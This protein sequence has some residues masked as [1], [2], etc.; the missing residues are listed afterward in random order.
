M[1]RLPPPILTSAPGQVHASSVHLKRVLKR[2]YVGSVACLALACGGG[3]TTL[4]VDEESAADIGGTPL[5]GVTNGAASGGYG[6]GGRP[7]PNG[8]SS[9][10]GRHT[11]KTLISGGHHSGGSSSTGGRGSGG[12]A[13]GG[14][15]VTGGRAPTG[16]LASTGGRAPTGGA[17]GNGGIVTGGAATGWLPTG[18]MPAIGGAALTGGRSS[19]GG[20]GNTGNF[21]T[22]GIGSGGWQTGGSV[23]SG[24]R[25]GSGGI[26][27]GGTSS[28]DPF[29]GGMPSM[30][31]TW[32]TGG[33]PGN[34]GMPTGGTATGG[35]STG[36]A[37]GNG[38]HPA[39]GGAT[40]GA[41][42][43]GGVASGGVASGGTATGGVASGGTLAT[44]GSPCA[45][46]PAIPG[47]SVVIDWSSARAATAE[48][49][50]FFDAPWPE[51]SRSVAE[52][53]RLPNPSSARG[54]QYS[55]ADPVTRLI[56]GGI[57]PLEYRAY[58]NQLASN[59]LT[60]G[61]NSAAI[62]FRFDGALNPLAFPSAI[63]TMD[64][65]RSPILLFRVESTGARRSRL[66]PVTS[67]VF[68]KSRY[69]KPHTLSLLPHPGFPLEP[70]ALYAAVILRSLGDRGGRPLGSP[71]AM[72]RAKHSASCLGDPTYETAFAAL[73]ADFSIDRSAVAAMTVFRTGNPAAPLTRLVPAI[74]RIAGAAL[75]NPAVETSSVDEAS[76]Y[77]LVDGSFQ[78]PI[79][80]YADP[81]YLPGIGVAWSGT[82]PV[83]KVAFDPTSNAGRF[84]VEPPPTS[85]T[86]P[87]LAHPRLERIKFRMTLPLGQWSKAGFER[88]PLA[89]VGPG[90][91][92]D[93]TE[94]TSSG[95]AS[96]LARLGIATFCA[97][98][99][100]H[101]ERAHAENVDPNLTQALALYDLFTGQD[102]SSQFSA[103]IANG[104]LFFNP[105]NLQAAKGNSLQAALDYAWQAHF[106]STSTL[107]VLVE[108]TSIPVTFD[109]DKVFFFGHSQGGATGPLLSESGRIGSMVLSAP[110]GH[111]VSNLLG[112][113]KPAQPFE[114]SSAVSSVI[115]DDPSEPL[116]AHHP[117][118]NVL[119]HWFEQA[120]AANYAPRLIAESPNHPKHV[121]VLTGTDDHYVSPA[122]HDAITTAARLHELAPQLRAVPGQQLLSVI[123]PTAGYALSYPSLSGNLEVDG[124]LVTGAFAQYHVAT[125]SDDH[126]VYLCSAD[127]ITDWE[128][129]FASAA[130]G[131][132]PRVNH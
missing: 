48:S 111:L 113:T 94:A 71:A 78:T 95:I 46:F 104:N 82:T 89:I 17:L 55:V 14:L 58:V 67:R 44:G 112:K 68:E 90:T 52:L 87:D 26:A 13:I 98:P 70:D 62:F 128:T 54:C 12:K 24:G 49:L 65:T 63:E 120:D 107:S 96:R 36:G 25:V 43:G 51:I 73:E 93:R 106:L 23:A 132:T 29:T 50:D 118:L 119:L 3:R 122:S 11:G 123:A 38:G 39:G 37:P 131:S 124:R 126:F 47:T 117:Q 85:A 60:E 64:A 80:Q 19:S 116:D 18:G 102:T 75:A 5:G 72:E 74:E 79:H 10:G 127:A 81:P 86:T 30:G 83:L 105:L 2:N 91:G 1:L 35:T 99:V 57:D 125:C 34:G 109:P 76:D 77:I 42:T 15:P 115:C 28:S 32:V 88:I 4:D 7:W 16:G 130:Q 121:F 114:T 97:T 103:S 9:L 59:F 101:Q 66:V 21:P 31:G 129:F 41:E 108:Q 22:G 110:S 53:A 100:M 56:A 92:A 69:L 84:L 45:A 40:G 20:S 33:R 6:I 27:T 61:P 8:G